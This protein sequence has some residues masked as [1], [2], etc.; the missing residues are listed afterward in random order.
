MKVAITGGTGF[1]GRCLAERL[2]GAG[3]EVVLVARGVD[4]SSA[5]PAV[6]QHPAVTVAPANVADRGSLVR[7]LE[8]CASVVHAAGINREV[9]A[10]SFEA[11]HVRGTANVVA[12]A[13]QVGAAHV[14]LLSF[15]RARP[16]C[17]SP[18]HES[19]WTAEEIVRG[20]SLAWTVVK[21][22]VVY[23]P[24]DQ[25][26]GHLSR[27]LRML[28]VYVGMGD[29]PVRPVWVGD[30][31]AVL[32]AAAADRRLDGRTVPVVGPTELGVDDAVR[33]I[34]R[35]MDRRIVALRA[36]V[37]FHRLLA[38]V[39]ERVT[40]VP[41]VSRAQV[42][43]LEEGLVEPARAPDELPADLAPDTAFTVERVRASLPIR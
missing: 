33:V 17:G 15:L 2:T 41:L 16:D 38:R 37:V 11:V 9:G 13:E 40:T 43:M 4:R 18:Y 23:G 3:H 36:P 10:Q 29:R 24:G 12:A 34:A 31:A 32:V 28:P 25:F 22:G 26:V 5:A 19:K 27:T 1:V 8:G 39:V 7:A 42:R 14:T 20:S 35:A 30:L 21:P 6:A